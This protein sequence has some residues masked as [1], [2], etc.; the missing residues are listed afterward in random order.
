[1]DLRHP[2]QACL[3]LLARADDCQIPNLRHGMAQRAT[4]LRDHGHPT[5]RMG[6]SNFLLCPLAMGLHTVR[7][8]ICIAR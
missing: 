6:T 4:G 2:R 8:K 7:M 1:M 3:L 5:A